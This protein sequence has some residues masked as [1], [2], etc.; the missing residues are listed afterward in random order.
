MIEQIR[1]VAL[2]WMRERNDIVRKTD[3]VVGLT[4]PSTES[5]QKRFVEAHNRHSN[6]LLRV[7]GLRDPVLY[8]AFMELVVNGRSIINN[9]HI[10]NGQTG[11]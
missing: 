3:A 10:I 6:E 1:D 8:E 2:A 11:G 5:Q 9:V 7:I 4:I